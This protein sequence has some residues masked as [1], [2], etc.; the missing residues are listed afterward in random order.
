MASTVARDAREASRKKTTSKKQQQDD[1]SDD[2]QESQPEEP[3]TYMEESPPPPTRPST[4][5]DS[6]S[7]PRPR[8]RPRPTPASGEANQ[9]RRESTLRDDV[10]ADI[11]EWLE[12]LDRA[13]R[14]DVVAGWRGLTEWE[15]QR[16]CTMLRN[17][18]LV[19]RLALSIGGANN[20]IGKPVSTAP[21]QTPAAEP[22]DDSPTPVISSVAPP[23]SATQVSQPPPPAISPALN[24]QQT[25]V[26][27]DTSLVQDSSTVTPTPA[28]TT[29]ASVGPA[30]HDEDAVAPVAD[31]A[32]V[33]HNSAPSPTVNSNPDPTSN[34]AVGEVSP[35]HSTA[36]DLPAVAASIDKT[37]WPMWVSEHFTRFMDEDL[38]EEEK[39]IWMRII[40]AWVGIEEAQQFEN[41]VS[42]HLCAIS[43]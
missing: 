39:S 33:D 5:P 41:S 29:P 18:W 9:S 37:G 31:K 6:T 42:N 8:R 25:P 40:I 4:A 15:F 36:F 7:R 27:D 19:E 30:L 14:D 34:S 21:K 43:R 22:V 35:L 10:P 38:L 20:P 13:K 26:Q 11:L 24:E 2:S 23:A 28:S 16:E 17:G 1:E 32:V 3:V 12:K